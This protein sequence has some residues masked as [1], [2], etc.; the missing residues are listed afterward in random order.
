MKYIIAFVV[1]TL[2]IALAAFSGD[3]GYLGGESDSP[4][5]KLVYGITETALCWTDIPRSVSYYTNKYEPVTGLLLGVAE[6][7]LVGIKDCAEGT[8]DT[9]FFLF[10][11]YETKSKNFFQKIK[12]WDKDIKEHLW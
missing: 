1:L 6:G 4:A 8:I 10:P 12:E 9:A 7:T 11:P 2:V 5:T 3:Y